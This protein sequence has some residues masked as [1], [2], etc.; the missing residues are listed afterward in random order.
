MDLEQGK[1]V[2][3]ECLEAALDYVAR[4]WSALC[5]CPPDHVGVGKEHNKNCQSRGK[6]PWGPWKEYQDTLPTEEELREKWR[7]LPVANVGMA[8]G[9]V[10]GLIG[11]D[12]DGP[13]GEELLQKKSAGDLPLTLEFFTPGG[14][15]RLLYRIPNGAILRT[16]YEAPAKKQELRFQ[17]KGA[18]TVMPPSRHSNGGRYKW[19]QAHGPGEIES[20]MAPA[21]LVREL[22]DKGRRSSGNKSDWDKIY[23]GVGEGSRNSSAAAFIGKLLA[24]FVNL[25]DQ[26]QVRL[27]WV[28]SE[29]WNERNDPPLA[30]SELKTVFTSILGAEKRQRAAKDQDALLRV[31]DGEISKSVQSNGQ[32]EGAVPD[33]HLKIIDSKPA[34]FLLRA[35]DWKDSPMID[36]GYLR[37]SESQITNWSTPSNSI[38][39]AAMQQAHLIVEKC[40]GWSKPGGPL[41]KL[42]DNAEHI[43]A[44][45]EA[46]RDVVV[47]A[48][49]K[50]MIDRARVQKESENGEVMLSPRGMPTKLADGSVV[51]QVYPLLK[52]AK[53]DYDGITRT[54][55]MEAIRL[56]RL[57]R[58]K[59]GTKRWW[60]A[61]PT[62]ISQIASITDSEGEANKNALYI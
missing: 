21:W 20:A 33:W 25:D 7:A 46:K 56:C 1:Q 14:G 61:T 3:K 8:Y 30:D 22:E 47:L 54:E 41:Q 32:A 38:R 18:Q 23:D 37:L 12:V 31:I 26:E 49:L 2:G 39:S 51:F 35:P 29:A 50:D 24:S 48:F 6:A 40:K 36:G 52:T 17:A 55:L 43:P 59:L 9:P 13:A 58:V 28:S 34:V 60:K 44:P 5:L 19:V 45:P 53:K 42:L 15:R 62:E 16:T 57:S 11:I 4:G 10:S 27:A